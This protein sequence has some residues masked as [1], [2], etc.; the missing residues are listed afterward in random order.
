MIRQMRP[1][2]L[3]CFIDHLHRLDHESRRDRFNGPAD[4]ALLAAYARHCFADG[5][6]VIGY[7]EDGRV[8]GAAELHERPE[9]SEPTAEIAFSVERPFQHRGLG[10][11]LFERLILH[12]LGLG[13]SR[14]SVTTHS[15]NEAMKALA[16]RFKAKLSFQQGEAVGVIEL[17]P[18]IQT[19]LLRLG[20]A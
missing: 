20:A 3:P 10:G 2:D 15:Q 6:T 17:D 5:T 1:S 14:L 19:P 8:F 11:L 16:R 7:F 4:D 13:Y 9:E 18:M 12:A